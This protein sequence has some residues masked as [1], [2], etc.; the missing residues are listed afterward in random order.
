M[1]EAEPIPPTSSVTAL[2]IPM[3]KKGEYDLWSMKM[4]Q[5]RLSHQL[6]PYTYGIIKKSPGRQAT[7]DPQ[8]PSAMLELYGHHKSKEFGGYYSRLPQSK[9]Q[10]T[11]NNAFPPVLIHMFFLSSTSILCLQ[12]MMIRLLQIDEMLRE[13]IE[14]SMAGG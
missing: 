1:S 4:L 3:I 12:L 7:T 14:H 11:P 2:R 5:Y 9:V 13:E 10:T 6:D 8:H